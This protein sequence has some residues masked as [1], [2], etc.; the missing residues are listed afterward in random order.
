ME[1][2]QVAVV[3]NADPALPAGRSCG[4]CVHWRR[5]SAL[6]QDMKPESTVCDFAPS[7]F[8]AAPPAPALAAG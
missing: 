1:A 7:R 8:R 3:A 2:A 5:C 4:Q 6:I